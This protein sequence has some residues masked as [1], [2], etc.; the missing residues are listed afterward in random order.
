M[1]RLLATMS[2][3]VHRAPTESAPPP[4]RVEPSVRARGAAN[5]QDISS[6]IRFLVVLFGI[7]TIGAVKL[8]ITS[9]AQ[10]AAVQL[11]HARSEVHRSEIRRERLL[12]ER[13]MLR[14]PA[15]LQAAAVQ[16]QLEAP[17]DIVDVGA[18]SNVAP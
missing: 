5:A 18:A 14:Q 15:R 6:A 12:V 13:A 2:R 3:M 11:D 16:L 9:Q 1:S 8:A 10:Q 4:V 17:V 7:G